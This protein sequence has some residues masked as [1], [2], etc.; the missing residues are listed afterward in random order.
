MESK[1]DS[2][3]GSF[4]NK[5]AT[6]ELHNVKMLVSNEE[7]AKEITTNNLE[8]LKKAGDRIAYLKEK[9]YYPLEVDDIFLNEDT[10]IFDIESAK[11]Q[12]ARLLQQ[13]RTG[14]PV[15][16]FNDGEKITH[17]FTDKRP[18]TNFPLKASDM[19]DAP[20]V[21]YEF[22][23]ESP[24]YGL[25]VAGV[26]PYRQGKSAYSSSLGSV[27]VYKRMHDLTGEKY[28][29]MFVA[30]YCARPDKKETWEEQA[31]LLIKYYNARTLC[32]NDDISFI[33]YMKSKGDA[34]YL[35]KQPQWL[36]E[37]VPNTTVKR[38]YGVHRSAQKII[39]Y[40]HNCLK[41]YMEEVIHVEKNEAG[42]VI[43]E[44]IG[45]SK[46]FDPVLLEEIIQYNDQGNFDRIVAAELAI[47]QALKMDPIMGRVGGSGDDRV[48]AMFSQKQKNTLFSDS[49]G[50]FNSKKRK[51]FT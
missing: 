6:S 17:E 37:V 41:K 18:I 22:P 30:S 4:L 23:I 2:T 36:L 50:L 43:R 49:R 10:N 3:L 19:K 31:R 12:K 48:K 28:Q 44:Q 51:L 40:L 16:L 46:I 34:H 14:T 5:P 26:D 15:I 21:I 1:E 38:E 35:E 29:D 27:Y 11:R 45:V 24:P 13:E 25:Y 33:E 39:D 20:I 32:E 7:K 9:M 47:A 8:R 42:D